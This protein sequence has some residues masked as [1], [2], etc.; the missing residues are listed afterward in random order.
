MKTRQRILVVDDSP[1]DLAILEEI[2]KEEYA[3]VCVDDAVSALECVRG[4]ER[5]DLVLLDIMMPGVDGLSLCRQIRADPVGRGIPVIFVTAR[6]AEQDQADGFAAGGVDYVVKPVD[7]LVLKA[8]VRTHVELKLAREGLEA[9]N[10]I[11]SENVRLREEMEQVS[12][13]DLKNPLMIVMSIPPL[14]L[15][16]PN[17]PDDVAG[18]LRMI[19]DAARRMLD[20]VNLSVDL[21]RME[22]GSYV[23]R[24]APVDVVAVARQVAEP[25][26]RLV[27]GREMFELSVQESE[28]SFVIQTEESLLYTLLTNLFKN[29]MEASPADR[30]VSVRFSREATLQIAVHNEGEIPPEIRERFFDKFATAGKPGGLGLGTYSARLIARTLGGDIRFESSKKD[31]TTLFVTLPG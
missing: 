24:V 12:R 27:P 14:L 30:G 5:P 13:H 25:L 18:M 21:F 6:D 29:A 10:R 28:G 9:Q 17:I 23:P 8:R 19:Q 2:L 31:G 1:V 15:R 26:A 4:E 16:R 20:M 22:R 3:V 7:P 11:L